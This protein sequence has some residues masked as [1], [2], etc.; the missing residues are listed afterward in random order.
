M[1][2]GRTSLFFTLR[3]TIDCLVGVSGNLYVTLFFFWL[4]SEY[5]VVELFFCIMLHDIVQSAIFVHKEFLVHTVM[6][7]FF[8]FDRTVM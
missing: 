7:F 8:F 1:D 3:R 2:F 4:M 5:P 6:Y